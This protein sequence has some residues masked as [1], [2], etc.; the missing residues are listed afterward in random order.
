[1]KIIIATI[2]IAIAVNPTLAETEEKKCWKYGKQYSSGDI[3]TENGEQYQCK[4]GTWKP[5][6]EP[7]SSE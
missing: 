4:N 3:I 1:M 7:A 6:K 5:K 2:L